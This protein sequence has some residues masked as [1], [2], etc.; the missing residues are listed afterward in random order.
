[1]KHSKKP[2]STS[3][4]TPMPAVGNRRLRIALFLLI[5]VLA[6]ALLLILSQP[7]TTASFQPL[8]GKWLR[9]DGGYVLEVKQVSGEGRVEAAYKNPA[10]IH[11]AQAKAEREG[12]TIRLFVELRDVGYDGSTYTLNYDAERDELQGIYNQVS[13]GRSQRLEVVFVREK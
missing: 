8:V 4:A 11:V 9:L 7:G 12:D 6:P 10:P 5:A 3:P 2:L 13:N 1:M